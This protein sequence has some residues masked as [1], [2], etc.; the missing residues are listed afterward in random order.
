[1]DKTWMGYMKS[2]LKLSGWACEL[3]NSLIIPGSKLLRERDW[4]GPA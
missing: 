3:G 2:M 1:M 4:L